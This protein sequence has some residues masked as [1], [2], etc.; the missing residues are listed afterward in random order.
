MQPY[1]TI[2][3]NEGKI[4]KLHTCFCGAQ[5]DTY[6]AESTAIIYGEPRTAGR[7][8]SIMGFKPLQVHSL[9]LLP[10]RGREG[11]LIVN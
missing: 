8:S 3:N 9:Q 1:R 6:Y 11:S 2:R 10:T 4:I 5:F 7:P